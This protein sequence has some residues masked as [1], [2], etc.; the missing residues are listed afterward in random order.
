M[1]TDDLIERKVGRLTVKSFAGIKNNRSY[2]NCLCDC[3]NTKVVARN[4]LISKTTRS[5][6]CLQKENR[7]QFRNIFRIGSACTAFKKVVKEIPRK[8]YY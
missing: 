3:G 4:C 7:T 5:C 2:W 6:G 8:G 1:I